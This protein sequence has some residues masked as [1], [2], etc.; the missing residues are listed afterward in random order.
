MQISLKR[1]HFTKETIFST[2]CLFVVPP[3]TGIHRKS[4]V[5]GAWKN[6]GSDFG[7]LYK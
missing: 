1:L 2:W 6:T 3:V 7:V 4:F 5:E